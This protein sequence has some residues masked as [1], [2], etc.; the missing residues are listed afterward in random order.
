[1]KKIKM[2]LLQREGRE[3]DYIGV[4]GD[5]IFVVSDMLKHIWTDPKKTMWHARTFPYT[6]ETYYGDTTILEQ[7]VLIWEH[8]VE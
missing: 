8:E 1:M 2:Y 3:D 5:N 6:L 4:D 7:A